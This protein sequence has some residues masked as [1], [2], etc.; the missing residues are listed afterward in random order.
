MA[1]PPPPP[2]GGFAFPA[3]T[4]SDSG[5]RRRPVPVN[6]DFQVSAA[7]GDEGEE[8]ETTVFA[9]E[10]PSKFQEYLG[11]FFD[12][13]FWILLAYCICNALLWVGE[14]LGI[15]SPQFDQWNPVRW[16]HAN[17]HGLQ[18]ELFQNASSSDATVAQFESLKKWI[19]NGPGGWV[20]SKLIV[21]DYLSE[22]GRYER[23]LEV[24]EPVEK[25]EI[26]V[27]LPL[28]H[29]LSSEFCKQDL[30]D[31]TIREVLEAQQKSS[32]KVDI[33]AWTWITL[34]VIAHAGQNTPSHTGLR[35]DTMLRSEFVDA[36]LSYIPVFWHDDDLEWLKGTDLMDVHI[37]EVHAAVETEYHKLVYIVPAIEKRI[38]MIEFKKWAMVVMS[39]GENVDLPDRENRSKSTPQLAIMP[40]IDL[41]DHH[42]PMP[43]ELL[44]NDDDFLAFQARGSRTNVSYDPELAAVTLKTKEP[45]SAKSA[46]TVGYGVRPNADYLLYHGFT[47]PRE[48]SDRTLCTQ[49]A[50][51]ELPL[52]SDFP[53]WK[54]RYLS[55]SYRFALPACPSRRSTPH[56]AVAAARFLVATE[57]DVVSFEAR[58]AKD[59]SLLENSSA[60]QKEEKFL[61][62]VA[63]EAVAAVCDVKAAPPACKSPLSVTSERA[64]WELIKRETLKR[65]SLHK[66]TIDEDERILVEDDRDNKLTVNQRHAVIVRREE[67]LVLRQWCGVAV[68]IVAFLATPEGE[69]ASTSL[70][71]LPEDEKLENDEPRLRPNYWA[72]LIESREAQK[73]YA[74][75]QDVP[76]EC[77]AFR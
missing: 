35:F 34:F 28:S 46:V 17:P 15:I 25:D 69:Q 9:E 43:E 49:Y 33:A 14:K 12:Y 18:R 62:H 75:G 58:V 5:I 23:R 10:Q 4:A 32:E 29:V 11:I 24:K 20:S 76:A 71:R 41:V 13:L 2:S 31:Q 39:R 48:W 77:N 64:A 50:V 73:R 53:G 1:T 42:L 74:E 66:N 55:Q 60:I 16:W 45:L 44:F 3:G 61:H 57:D 70:T 68:R 59:P 63:Q 52:G 7:E 54:S 30:T 38:S 65:V 51:I 67:K 8:D 6:Y 47:M 56:V 37:M 72:R 40:L 27:R 19:E 26:L 22:R 21:L 36:A